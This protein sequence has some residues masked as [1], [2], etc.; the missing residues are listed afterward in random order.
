MTCSVVY[1]AEH[2]NV[3]FVE[4]LFDKIESPP[5]NDE[6]DAIPDVF[7]KLLLAFNLHFELPSENLVMLGVVNRGTAK[8]FTEKLML[9]F[10]RE[11]MFVADFV[12]FLVFFIFLSPG[13]RHCCQ[14][15]MLPFLDN[16]HIVS[17][18]IT[19]CR[20]FLFD[21]EINLLCFAVVFV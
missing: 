18:I 13:C 4:F 11:G 9:L 10:N 19:Y 17:S 20:L 5:A 21:D 7:I 8:T 12:L 15:A 6:A 2:I 16:H 3:N 14:V 1:H